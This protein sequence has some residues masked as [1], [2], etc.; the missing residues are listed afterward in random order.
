MKLDAAFAE[1]PAVTFIENPAEFL[2]STGLLFEINRR[3]LHPLGLALS[4]AIGENNE[5]VVKVW[6]GQAYLEGYEYTDETLKL[7]LEKLKKYFDDVGT[8]R[9]KQRESL[10]GYVVQELP[11][12]ESD[13]GQG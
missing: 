8:N 1:Y 3:V 5:T 7:G 6:N 12:E 9:T 10:L 11:E 2:V 4:L 13:E